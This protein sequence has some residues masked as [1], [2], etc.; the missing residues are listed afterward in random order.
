VNLRKKDTIYRFLRSLTFFLSAVLWT[1]WMACTFK[2]WYSLAQ[3]IQYEVFFKS[4]S[5]KT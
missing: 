4:V 5:L 2:C 3:I 1:Q